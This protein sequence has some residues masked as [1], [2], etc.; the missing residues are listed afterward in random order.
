MN[1]TMEMTVTIE[2]SWPHVTAVRDRHGKLRYRYR[3]RG[4]PSGYL[5]G[6]PG[7][8]EWES[9]YARLSAAASQ[10]AGARGKPVTPGSFDDLARRYRHSPRWKRMEPRTQYSFGLIMDRLLETTDRRG[11]RFGNRPVAAVTV[12]SLDKMLGKMR[13]TPGAANNMRKVMRMLFAYAVKLDWRRDNPATLTE[14]FKRGPGHHTWTDDEINQYRARHAYSTTARLVLELTLNT[15][16]RKCNIATL[17]RS[18]FQ[19]GKFHIEHAKGG[20]ATIVAASIETLAAIEAMPIAGI[21]HFVVTSF[22]KPFTANG[23]GNKVR[24]WC[25]EAGLPHCTLHGLRKAQSRRLAESGASDAQGR[26]VTGQKKNETFAYYAE[27]MNR[28]A[29][30]DTALSNMATRSVSNSEK[31]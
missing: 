22:G 21:G 19:R 6:E 16:A 5:H 31:L 30:A 17:Q 23:L 11:N 2:R 25:N 13:D 10:P 7:S 26:A 4:C 3:R 29:M 15:A 20:D 28:E 8:P 12:D 14:P 18:Q 9:D 1:G 24:E 27:K